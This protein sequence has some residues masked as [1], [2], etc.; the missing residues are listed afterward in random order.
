M[1]P[2]TYRCIYHRWQKLIPAFIKISSIPVTPLQSIGPPRSSASW[3]GFQLLPWLQVFPNISASPSIIL[4]YVPSLLV[5]YCPC[6][7]HGK[8][9]IPQCMSN[10]LPL[11]QFDTR[12]S[13]P[14]VSLVHSS[15]VDSHI[16]A[17]IFLKRHTSIMT[18]W[19]VMMHFYK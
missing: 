9:I 11:L 7:H 10:P 13:L 8:G 19:C 5:L 18:I 1:S 16:T 4:L 15:K 6:P 3:L 14:R 12:Y 17:H 2:G